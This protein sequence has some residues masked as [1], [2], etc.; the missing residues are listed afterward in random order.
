ML[1][2][3]MKMGLMRERG[4]GRKKEVTGKD[5][6]KLSQ[7]IDHCLNGCFSIYSFIHIIPIIIHINPYTSH[8]ATQT[9]LITRTHAFAAMHALTQTFIRIFIT[10]MPS[11]LA[12][13]TPILTLISI[14]P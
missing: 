14:Y 13:L 6:W 2:L 5:R 3:K 8:N 7:K 9:T 11:M 10:F 12:V 4:N 1:A